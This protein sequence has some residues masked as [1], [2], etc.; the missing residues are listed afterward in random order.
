MLQ[1]NYNKKVVYLMLVILHPNNDTYQCIPINIMD[2][3]EFWNTL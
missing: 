3:T 2:L 1:K